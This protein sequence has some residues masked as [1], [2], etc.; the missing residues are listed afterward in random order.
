VALAVNC[1]VAPAAT[2]AVEGEAAIEVTV[3]AAAVTVSA[4][5]PVTPLMVAVIDVLPALSPVA[6]PSSLSVATAGLDEAQATE[7]VR[8]AVDPSL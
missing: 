6:T 8:F 5:E 7:D 1:C 4:T 2:L 3:T